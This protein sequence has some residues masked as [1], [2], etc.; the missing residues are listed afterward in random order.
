MSEGDIRIFIFVSCSGVS[1]PDENK[2]Q[3]HILDCLGALIELKKE[4][5][6]LLSLESKIFFLAV[7]SMAAL[8]AEE[9]LAAPKADTQGHA[10]AIILRNFP[11]AKFIAAKLD[12]KVGRMSVPSGRRQNASNWLC[13]HWVAVVGHNLS[14][15]DYRALIE[16]DPLSVRSFDG[17]KYKASCE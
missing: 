15:S 11:S 6:T 10:E 9:I 13:M 5:S 3:R 16:A 17:Q 12:L 1:E 4:T 14:S 7:S 2:I 8:A